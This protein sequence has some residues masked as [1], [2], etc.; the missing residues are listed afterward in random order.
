M[1]SNLNIRALHFAPGMDYID[2]L[3]RYCRMDNQRCDLA[4]CLI[5]NI[6]GD[7]DVLQLRAVLDGKATFVVSEDG[8]TLEYKAL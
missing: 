8:L 1:E 7:V 4:L 3:K 5:E 2:F 6:Q